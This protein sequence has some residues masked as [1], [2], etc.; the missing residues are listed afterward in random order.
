[1]WRN[2]ASRL[3]GART[4]LRPGAVTRPQGAGCAAPTAWVPG[5]VRWPAP[6]RFVRQRWSLPQRCLSTVARGTETAS[7]GSSARQETAR[8]PE[9]AS[10]GS[11]QG[12]VDGAKSAASSASLE[13]RVQRLEEAVAAQAAK[14]DEVDKVAKKRGGIVQLVTQFGAPFALWYALCWLGMLFAIY[15]LL[16]AGIISWQESLR[17]LL[18]GLGLDSVCDRVDPSMGNLVIA[19][20]VNELIEPVRFPFVI[21]TG[22]PAIGAIRR[23][24]RMPPTKAGGA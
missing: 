3:A 5:T 22:M 17:P 12:S 14:L 13:E 21:A 15:M 9:T 24:L 20:I 8:E 1:M 10:V 6:E 16:E 11:G 2:A 19:I 23:L 7:T 4:V 18:Q